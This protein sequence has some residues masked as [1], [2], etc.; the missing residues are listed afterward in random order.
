MTSS[1]DGHWV[2]Q[3]D[4]GGTGQV[5]L[6]VMSIFP[7]AAVSAQPL[8]RGSGPLYPN[9]WAAPRVPAGSHTT[10]VTWSQMI[11][12]TTAPDDL[13]AIDALYAAYASGAA[14]AGVSGKDAATALRLEV[15]PNPARG[16]ATLAWTNPV[17]GDVTLDVL[18]IAGR[19]VARLRS[20]A[21]PAGP[22]RATWDGRGE[23]GAR[24]APG[25]YLARLLTPVGAA[26]TS[27]VRAN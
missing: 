26:T 13:A 6:G 18:D 16:P 23:R 7:P 3:L 25:V 17:A 2:Q 10:D 8:V 27:I 14:L 19:H 4:R 24:V 1:W 5:D 21:S 11:A 15:A 9:G 22:Q 20:G 12:F